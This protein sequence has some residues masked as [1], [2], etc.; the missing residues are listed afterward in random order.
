MLRSEQHRREL[1]ATCRDVKQGAKG[2][3]ITTNPRLKRGFFIF[4][5]FCLPAPTRKSPQSLE[6]I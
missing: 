2:E 4:G 5:L 1:G 3:P 6:E